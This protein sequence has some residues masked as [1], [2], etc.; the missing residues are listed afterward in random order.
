MK[1]L[2]HALLA[3][4]LIPL[5]GTQTGC[6]ETIEP[7][8]RGVSVLWGTANPDV[9]GEG[10]HWTGFASVQE[11][12]V[13]EKP[14]DITG[15]GFTEDNQEVDFTMVIVT[16]LREEGVFQYVTENPRLFS[17]T[18]EPAAIGSAKEILKSYD[19]WAVNQQREV[20]AS[21]TLELLAATMQ[22]YHLDIVSVEFTD[23][24]LDEQFMGSIKAKQQQEV[25]AQE[26]KLELERKTTEAQLTIATATAE[27]AATRERADAEA[28]AITTVGNALRTNPLVL[29]MTRIE[30]WNGVMPSTLING[31]TN[32]TL[33]VGSGGN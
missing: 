11:V 5:F 20:I 23:I 17:G 19:V 25:K 18:L 14:F 1:N 4:L 22:D 3:L 12:N 33:L 8:E 21:Q 7:G 15:S 30:N 2:Y 24:Q 29:E 27:A 26:A 28:Y 13:Q 16:R 32:S 31:S 6:V 9:M 10:F